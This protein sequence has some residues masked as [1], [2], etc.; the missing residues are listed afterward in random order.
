MGTEL[1]A[2]LGMVS[3]PAVLSKAKGNI[4]KL[5]G[6]ENGHSGRPPPPPSFE[7]N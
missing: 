5:R 7:D 6:P 1:G 3:N 2:E 4:H